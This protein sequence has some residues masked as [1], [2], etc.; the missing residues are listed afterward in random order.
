L[1]ETYASPDAAK[2]LHTFTGKPAE[3]QA[4]AV[5]WLLKPL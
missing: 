5:R 1:R 3:A 4:D 2:Q